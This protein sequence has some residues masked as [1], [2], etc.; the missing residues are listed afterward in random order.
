VPDG[1]R[2]EIALL[3]GIGMWHVLTSPELQR[4]RAVQRE[5]LTELVEALVDTAPAKLD[6]PFAADYKTAPDD[7]TRLRVVIDQV[8]SLTDPSAQAWHTALTN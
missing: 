5:L 4:R 2:A 3:K 6:A 8:A 1:T 7:A